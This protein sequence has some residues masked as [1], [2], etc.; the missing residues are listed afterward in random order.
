MLQQNLTTKDALMASAVIV[1]W[2]INFLFMKWALQELSPLI[3]GLLRFVCVIFPAIFFFKCPKVRWYWLALYGLTISFGQFTLMFSAL[4]QGMPTGLAALVVQGQ[5]FFTVLLSAWLFGEPVKHH[6]F[7]G[8]LLAATGLGLIGVGQYQGVMPLIGLV[9]VLGAAL[10]W[11]M[12]NLVLKK[13]G[14]VHPISLVVWGNVSSLMAFLLVSV[15]VYGVDEIGLQ[16]SQMSGRVGGA[17]LYLAYVSGLGYVGWGM[18]L[19]RYPASKITP[20]ALLVP[21]VAMLT[22]FLFLNESLNGWHWLGV[23][24]VMLALLIH[25]FGGRYRH[26][27]KDPLPEK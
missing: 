7:I 11:G 25:V 16:L 12:G 27:K 13:I 14:R 19:A 2:G 17:V 26:N 5:A 3:L 20:L 10:S 8:M 15:L 1:A 22:A 6:Q 24:T 4:A 18:L 9:L 23:L 21:V